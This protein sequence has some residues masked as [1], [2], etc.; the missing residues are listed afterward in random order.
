MPLV[1]RFLV[2]F[3]EEGNPAGVPTGS[4]YW[5]WTLPV[6]GIQYKATKP[7]QAERTEDVDWAMLLDIFGLFDVDPAMG[8]IDT[9]NR[10]QDLRDEVL[11]LRDSLPIGERMDKTAA[12]WQLVVDTLATVPTPPN[13]TDDTA[14]EL[15]NAIFDDPRWGSWE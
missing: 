4:N 13:W 5:H 15:A 9:R 7:R 11:A 12:L 1:T 8:R 2:A 3:G 14:H 10:L 6:A